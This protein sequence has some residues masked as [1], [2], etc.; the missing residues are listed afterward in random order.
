MLTYHD[1]MTADFGGLSAAADKWQE[2]ADEFGK[3]EKRYRDSVEKITMDRTWLGDSANAARANFAATRYEYEAA[4]TQAKATATLLRNAHTHFTELKKQLES[5][6][7]DAIKAGMKVSDQGEVTYDYD[8]LTAQERGTAMNHPGHAQEIQTAVQSWRDHLRDRVKFV[9]D[10]DNDL[11][12]DLEA[13][14]KD[15]GGNKNDATVGGFNGDAG[16]VAAADDQAKKARTE[17]ASV[18]EMRENESLDDYLK[19][20]QREGITR[21][22]GNEQL[23]KTITAYLAGTAKA[24]MVI[25][26]LSTVGSGIFKLSKYA[27]QRGE[28]A[29]N[30]PGSMVAKFV[31]TKL[32]AAQPGSLLSKIPPNLP[33]AMYGSD[34]AAEFGAHMRKG[35]YFIPKSYQANL[36]TVA[37]N[38]GLGQAAK[39]AGWLRGA[40]IVGSAGAT[41]YG[42]ANLATYNTD[43]I[44]ADPAKFAT[45]VTG[46]AFNASLTAMA[47]APNPITVGLALGTGAAYLGATVWDNHEEIMDAGRAAADWTGKTA[48]KI[49]DGV[50]KGLDKVGD[51]I[52]SG[53]KK[54][55]NNPFD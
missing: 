54:I 42:V 31:N 3:V 10:A 5:S 44:K 28:V 46:T 52:A 1:V 32:A 38:G 14:V 39:A 19:R 13:V 2:T 7:A 17:L 4:Q 35:E 27:I 23:A 20:L 25:E 22:T 11:K 40:G 16:K 34:L 50:S 55:F 6:R 33:R 9:D 41:V 53:A 37:K 45:E 30:A 48:E 51:G 21:L 8:R 49:G 29:M 18:M 43:M 36:A 24:A 47:V 15:A 26:A 12:K